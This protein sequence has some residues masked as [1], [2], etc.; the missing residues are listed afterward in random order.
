MLFR[1][2]KL[3]LPKQKRHACQ[4]F[5]VIMWTFFSAD[6]IPLLNFFYKMKIYFCTALCSVLGVSVETHTASGLHRL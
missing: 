3:N 2:I 1:S 6:Q 5:L 4:Q